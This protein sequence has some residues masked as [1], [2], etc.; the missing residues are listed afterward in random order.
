M[1]AIL[2][3][4]RPI[5][6]AQNAPLASLDPTT[7]KLFY[8]L[9]ANID[10]TDDANIIPDFSHAGYGG[11]GVALPA[12]DSIPTL[13]TL[14]PQVGD[15]LARIQAALEDVA[16][17]APDARGIR[18]A[19]LLTA[20]LYELSDTLNFPASG[21]ILRG[22]GQGPNGT[23]LRATT[24]EID[25]DFIVAKGEGDGENP[26]EA[27]EPRLTR[28][29]SDY[30]SVG[31]TSIEVT[32]AAG[33]AIGDAIAIKRTP[34]ETW[35]GSDGVD[36]AQF[37]WSVS[38]YDVSFQR[39]V[40]SIDG[41]A[42]GFDIP[43]VDT[44]E[45]QYGGGEVYRIDLSERLSQI[46]I[47]NLRLETRFETDITRR[48]R[49]NFAIALTEVENSWIRD[50]TVRYFSKGF[51]FRNGVHFVTAQNVAHIDP[52]FEVEGGN[53]YAFDFDGG[54]LNLVQRCYSEF[55]RHAFTSGSRATGPN[56]FLDCFAKNSMNDSGPHQ[57]WA[58]GTLF[59]NT[60]DTLIRVQNRG[61]SGTGHGWAGAQQ[62]L[63]NGIYNE[64]L[65]E[66]PPGAM[67]W[68]VG[69]IGVLLEGGFVDNMPSG[70]IES[71]GTEVLPRSLYL[72][73]LEDRLGVAAIDNIAVP[74]QKTGP[75]YDALQSWAGDSTI[76]F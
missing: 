6:E 50:V 64:I 58:V 12:Y 34:N 27:A 38:Q 60:R 15:D 43:L 76:E 53:H 61:D 37:D 75:L 57:R 8:G 52:N 74:A 49:G 72:Q 28:I 70:I 32:S 24:T 2:G 18:G 20:G 21:V 16:A 5:N 36:T 1:P 67:N 35:L 40:T 44:I 66:A 22:E 30:V 4:D 62:M 33:Y 41:A 42:I 25:A 26:A 63:W 59:D 19:V 47:E 17:Q 54:G 69:N 31:S 71:E 14:S 68:A 11:G 51:N 10:S 73:Q 48:D 65:L 9:Y 55:S 3:F 7:G 39:T 23:I 13:T 46:G 45:T 56:V 29:V